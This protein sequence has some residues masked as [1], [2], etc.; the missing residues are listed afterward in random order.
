MSRPYGAMEEALHTSLAR[1]RAA[2]P[3]SVTEAY[4]KAGGSMGIRFNADEVFA[5][6][7]RIEANGAAFYRRAAELH[8]EA[9]KVDVDL[10]LRLAE[11][12]D[13]HRDTFAVLRTELSDRMREETAFDPY[14]EASLYLQELSDSHG[15][16][17]APA[18]TAAL[19]GE[20]TTEDLLKTA[21]GLEQKSITFYEG[22]KDMVPRKLGHDKLDVIIAEEKHHVAVL[23]NELKEVRGDDG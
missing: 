2:C 16:E 22:L 8:R 4:R 17:G 11:M 13:R 10:L 6:A 14:M 7:E 15:G 20:E 5:M 19:S 18:V 23:A 3:V 1:C 12:E 21:I 9:G